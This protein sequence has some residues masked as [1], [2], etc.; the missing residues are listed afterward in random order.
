MSGERVAEILASTGLE[1][2]ALMRIEDYAPGRIPGGYRDCWHRISPAQ[3][4]LALEIANGRRW[5][6]LA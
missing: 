2:G 6:S 1:R 4:R 5:R 3:R